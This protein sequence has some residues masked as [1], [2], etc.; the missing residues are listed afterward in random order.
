M[1]ATVPAVGRRPTVPQNDDG[2][3]MLPA[4]S[5]PVASQTWPA[6]SA[7]AE[8][9]DEP[10]QVFVVSHGLYVVPNTSLCVVPPAANSG[11][12]DL[13]ITMAPAA[14]SRSTTTSLA[15]AMRCSNASDPLVQRTPP[16]SMLSFT[17]IGSPC[18][19]PRGPSGP[20]GVGHGAA[21]SRFAW[22][23]ARSRQSVGSALIEPSVAAIRAAAAS[24]RSS[25]ETSRRSSRSTAAQAVR[26]VSS[27]I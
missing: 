10:P 15:G 7:A 9:P 12:F 21:I 17:A 2:I 11:R 5:L 4:K 24:T 16:T 18:S 6:A 26:R 1:R 13:P 23:R 25:G 14:S 20:P 19:R 27:V 8:P 22:S 3:R